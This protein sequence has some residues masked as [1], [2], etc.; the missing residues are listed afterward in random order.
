MDDWDKLF[1]ELAAARGRD[2][3]LPL[4]RQLATIFDEAGERNAKTIVNQLVSMDS[5]PTNLYGAVRSRWIEMKRNSE[6]ET[7]RKDK[8]QSE[9]SENTNAAEWTLYWQIIEEIMLWHQCGLAETNKNAAPISYDI[10]EWL[11]AGK[12][13]TWSPIL[14]HF[15]DGYALGYKA[16]LKTPGSL[17]KYLEQ[18]LQLIKETRVKRQAEKVQKLKACA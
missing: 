4:T 6:Y 3:P 7:L 16:D 14:D 15:L 17:T 8:W 12:P 5:L 18:Y 2:L 10:D 13:K 1:S 11:N 9:S